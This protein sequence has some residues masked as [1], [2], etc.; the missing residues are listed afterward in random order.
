MTGNRLYYY[1]EIRHMIYS[2]EKRHPWKKNSK[3]RRKP[4]G[5]M[6]SLSDYLPDTVNDEFVI[7]KKIPGK[8]KK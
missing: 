6:V 1:S 8:Q 2:V 3:G 7:L 5:E 4:R